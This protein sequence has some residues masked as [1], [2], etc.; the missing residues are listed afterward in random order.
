MAD[1]HTADKTNGENK[2]K[3]ILV[4]CAHPDDEV[5]GVGSTIAKYAKEGCKTTAV[6]FSY[7]EGSHPW[8]KRKVTVQTRVRESKAASNILGC[9]ELVFLGLKEGHFAEQARQR[10]SFARIRDLI[11]EKKPAK[12][13]IHSADDPHPDHKVIHSVVLDI[14]ARTGIKTEVYSFDVWNPFPVRNRNLPVLIVDVSDTYRLKAKALQK[15]KSQ[16]IAM[17]L[18]IPVVYIKTIISGFN[19]HL[20]FA[21]VY[22]R[23]EP[24]IIG[25]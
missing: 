2:G 8:L 14:V 23:V 24:K 5:L 6:I 12:I 17:S 25:N 4:F 20:R 10:K 13:F 21:D 16:K 3:N 1:K 11:K 19:H 15:F 7:G 22:Y 18:L 9:D